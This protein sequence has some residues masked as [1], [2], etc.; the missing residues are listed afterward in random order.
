[1]SCVEYKTV[2]TEESTTEQQGDT[3]NLRPFVVPRARVRT[4]DEIVRRVAEVLDLQLTQG[5][6]PA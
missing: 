1:M 4:V 3:R 6:M 2:E 5:S